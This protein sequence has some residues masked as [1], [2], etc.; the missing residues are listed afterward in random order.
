MAKKKTSVPY[1]SGQ[2][3]GVILLIIGIIFLLVDLG[4]WN[5]WGIQWWTVLFLLWGIFTLWKK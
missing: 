5:F 1:A 3:C 4:K 2:L